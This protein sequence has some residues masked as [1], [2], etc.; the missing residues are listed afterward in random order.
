MSHLLSLPVRLHISKGGE[1]HSHDGDGIVVE[2]GRHIFR[3]ELVGGVADEKTSLANGTVADD[4]APRS[5][6]QG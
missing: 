5:E 6:L 2:D 1:G 3:R 4:N